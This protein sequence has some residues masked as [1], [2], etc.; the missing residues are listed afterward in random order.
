MVSLTP[1]MAGNTIIAMGISYIIVLVYSIYMA[2][3]GYKQA[4][5][6]IQMQ[7]VITI[8]KEIRDKK[9]I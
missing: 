5:V 9:R 8:L 6:N 7:E 3:L 2:Y 1:D 4:K